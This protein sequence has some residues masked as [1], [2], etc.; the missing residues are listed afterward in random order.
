MGRLFIVR[1]GETEENRQRILQGHLPGVLTPDGRRQMM[2]TAEVLSGYDCEFRRLVVSDLRRTMESA[3]IVAERLGLDEIIPT[4][5]LRERDWGPYTGMPISEARQRYCRD[6]VWSLPG[7]E[8]E[9]EIYARAQRA[10]DF[11]R[12]LCQDGHVLVVTHGLFA[13]NLVAARFGCQF[14]EVTPLVNG[15]VRELGL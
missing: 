14:R 1:H 7:A 2:Q 8:T 12:P 3:A 15:E 9:D 13:R 11:L 10:L 4:P 6:G 5:L